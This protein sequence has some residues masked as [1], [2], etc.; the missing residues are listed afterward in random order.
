ML[1]RLTVSPHPVLSMHALVERRTSWFM[2]SDAQQARW[3]E[4]SLDCW[5]VKVEW[6]NA[7]FRPF[8]SVAA[9][10]NSKGRPFKDRQM[11]RKL[12]KIVIKL[13]ILK[14]M[15]PLLLF[16]DLIASRTLHISK[17]RLDHW[18]DGPIIY[19]ACTKVPIKSTFRRLSIRL[20]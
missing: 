19:L 14:W 18:N 4:A 8:L 11:L 13:S 15:P 3:H 20:P 5:G 6:E 1:M 16:N 17:Q 7:M 12:I 10:K 9:H 2:S